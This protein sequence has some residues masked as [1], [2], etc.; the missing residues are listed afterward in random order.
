MEN[1][2]ADV[3]KSSCSENSCR[4]ATASAKQEYY[5][6]ALQKIVSKQK[7]IVLDFTS[8]KACLDP[9]K[10]TNGHHAVRLLRLLCLQQCI[11]VHVVIE[12]ICMLQF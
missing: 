2:L 3:G 6:Q 7:E 8:L 10:E 9:Q 4:D 12:C 11:T 5:L 1:V